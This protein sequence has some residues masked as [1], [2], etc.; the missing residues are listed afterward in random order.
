[1]TRFRKL[2]VIFSLC[3]I[4]THMFDYIELDEIVA[5]LMRINPDYLI[6]FEDGYI[7]NDVLVAE[8][9]PDNR[10]CE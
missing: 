1:M 9:L 3:I 6:S 2:I 5:A 4:G 8:I 7:P 10:G